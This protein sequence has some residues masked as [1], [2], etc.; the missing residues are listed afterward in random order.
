MHVF[1]VWIILVPG[2]GGGDGGGG[3]G[4]GYSGS[5]VTGR[6]TGLF[7]AQNKRFGISTGTCVYGL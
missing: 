2:G 6:W 1:F 5:L 3:E 7:G 4:G